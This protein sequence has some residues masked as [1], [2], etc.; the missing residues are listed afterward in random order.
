MAQVFALIDCNNFY[1]SCERLFAPQLKARPVVVLSNNDGCIIARSEEA[2]ALGIAMGE[3]YFKVAAFLEKHAVHVFSSNYALYGDLSQRVMAVLQQLEPFVEIYSIDEAFVSLPVAGGGDLVAYGL[4]LRETIRQWVGIPVSIGFGPTKTLAKIANRM[5][6][7]DKAGNGV[8]SLLDHPRLDALLAEVPV[9]AVWGIGRRHGAKLTA[10]G[11]RSAF[12]LK[13]GDDDWLRKH[14][15]IT[16]LRTAMELRG[17]SCLPFEQLPPAKKSI[18]SSR[19]FGRTVQGKAELFEAVATYVTMAAEKMRRA[20][21]VAGCLQVF[22]TTNRFNKDA[23]QYSNSESVRLEPPTASTPE[24]LSRARVCLDHLYRPGYAYQKA[25]V[26]LLDLLPEARQQ[27]HLFGGDS[28]KAGP[29]MAA[30]DKI[31]NRWGRETVQSAA[32]GFT[33]SWKNR[34]ERK[35]P[36][37][38]TCW[39]D[40][41]VVRASRR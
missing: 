9:G 27:G 12:D 10:C 4:K 23:P 16:G 34:Q 22:V 30:L 18:T 17:L 32:A 14:L 5:A 3:P 31:N 21:L 2:K 24:L 1:V 38:T 6:K 36:A 8:F 13:G 7:Q 40:L 41:P 15:T 11:I 33:K 37:Y 28:G 20:K 39:H 25:G 19:S 29:L 26:V 35:S